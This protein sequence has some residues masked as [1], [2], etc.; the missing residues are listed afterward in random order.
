[1]RQ[2]AQKRAKPQL[3]NN[4]LIDQFHNSVNECPLYICTCCDQLWY[5]HS[6]CPADRLR[7]QHPTMT[8]YLQNIVGVGNTEWLCQTCNRHLSKGKIRP[9]ATSNNMKFPQKPTFWDLNELECHSLVIVICAILITC[10]QSCSQKISSNY[11][12][13]KFLYTT[14]QSD[15]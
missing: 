5:R 8:K 15:L 6:V 4:E 2:Y 12:N 7:Q 10:N 11:L 13:F 9:C 14:L 1:M 3:N